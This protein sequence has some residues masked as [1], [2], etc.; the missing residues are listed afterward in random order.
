MRT[1]FPSKAA[2]MMTLSRQGNIFLLSLHRADNRFDFEST[3]A[4]MDALDEVESVVAKED[5]GRDEPWA[6][7]TTGHDRIYSN[8]L[9]PGKVF[10]K[11]QDF[12]SQLYHPLLL[13]MLTFPMPTVAA[14]NGHAFAGGWLFA[15][16][17]T[18]IDMKVPC[19]PGMVAILRA[20]FP[21][22]QARKFNA[23]EALKIGII[24]QVAE[25]DKVLPTAIALAEQWAPKAQA[26]PVMTMLKT[27][28]YQDA[29]HALKEGG[30]GH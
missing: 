12:S 6:L 28:M 25:A 27:D 14:I 18:I 16:A 5:P 3:K 9:D 21:T 1:H 10:A 20:K 29:V 19:T 17:T 24:D 7:V 2:A 15:M 22:P 30:L 11:M 8:G 4:I 13:R 23:T 26:G